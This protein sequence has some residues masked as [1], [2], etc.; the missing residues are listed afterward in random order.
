[1]NVTPQQNYTNAVV[2]YKWSRCDNCNSFEP[3]FNA[4]TQGLKNASVF[5]IDVAEQRD[6]LL[7]YNVDIGEGVPRMVVYNNNGLGSLFSGKRDVESVSQFS[8]LALIKVTPADIPNNHLA[9]YYRLTCPYCTEFIPKFLQLSTSIA[10]ID[11]TEHRSALTDLQPAA[12]NRTVPFMVLHKDGQQIPFRQ[13]RTD[14]NIQAFLTE[15]DA[16]KG[17]LSKSMTS[18][19]MIE[20]LEINPNNP[21]NIKKPSLV[22]FYRPTCGFCTKFIPEYVKLPDMVDVNVVAVNTDKFPRAMDS[23]LEPQAQS[24]GVPHVIFWPKNGKQIPY[25]NDR[26]ASSIMKFVQS[27]SGGGGSKTPSEISASVKTALKNS[28]SIVLFHR[29]GCGYCEEFMPLYSQLPGKTDIN[30]YTVDII[31]HRDDIGLLEKEPQGVP[32]VVYVSADDNQVVFDGDRDLASLLSFIGQQQQG[33]E[34]QGGGGDKSDD[35]LDASIET[36]MKNTPSIALFHR[37]GCGYCEEFKPLYSQLPGK[38]DISVYTVDIIKHKNKIGLLEK[39]PEGV[40]HVVYFSADKKQVIY[41]GSRDVNGLT[42]FIKEQKEL[43]GGQR[44]HFSAKNRTTMREKIANVLDTLQNMAHI[45]LGATF[46][47]IFEPEE[48]SVFFIGWKITGKPN[49]DRLY[50]MLIPKDVSGDL[51]TFAVIYGSRKGT[52]TAKIYKNKNPL[53][54]LHEKETAGY[55][56]AI[57]SDVVVQTMHDIGYKVRLDENDKIRIFD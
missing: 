6:K 54:L 7:E 42:N 50:I 41:E 12:Q 25:K 8:K 21:D 16:L 18:E 43:S 22:L 49:F 37:A 10:A 17:G 30:V 48:S 5:S 51:P 33:E 47:D 56:R 31:K 40:P 32:H 3:I 14:A 15:H 34:V 38:T 19:E 53:S 26:T 1:M 36:V 45:Q 24:K 9:L 27:L 35:K 57:E 28:P 2:L 46:K 4:A 39:E 20:L 11:I 29:D 44:V 52:L 23:V 55:R 13:E